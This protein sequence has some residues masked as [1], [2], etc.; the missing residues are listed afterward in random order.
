MTAKQR[1]RPPS[2]TFVR[3]FLN[4]SDS[5]RDTITAACEQTAWIDSPQVTADL[6]AAHDKAKALINGSCGDASWTAF[7]RALV[8]TLLLHAHHRRAKH[9]V[10][11]ARR[12]V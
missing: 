6:A 1:Y 3:V 9:H 11:P 2:K 10:N 7:A 12:K 8:A 4:P 5:T